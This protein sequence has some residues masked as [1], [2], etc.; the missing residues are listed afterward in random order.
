MI[1]INL[2]N[3]YNMKSRYSENIFCAESKNVKWYI[4]V[5]FKFYYYII[6]FAKELIN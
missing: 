2:I 4:D 3:L 5:K 6:V 1:S